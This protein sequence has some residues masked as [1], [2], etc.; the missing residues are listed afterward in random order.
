[1]TNAPPRS[2]YGDRTKQRIMA[3]LGISRSLV[4]TLREAISNAEPQFQL[5]VDM[6]LISPEDSENSY[7]VRLVYHDGRT[8]TVNLD[9]IHVLNL[10]CQ[11][12]RDILPE[13]YEKASLQTI[14]GFSSSGLS[15]EAET[16]DSRD[17]R[18][19][20]TGPIVESFGT[21]PSQSGGTR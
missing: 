15:V 19:R 17:R 12:G 3:L 10:L 18:R 8:I 13:I 21:L 20:E 7:E 14:Q 11:Q 5:V 1:M 2:F 16:F 9:A 6:I 4:S